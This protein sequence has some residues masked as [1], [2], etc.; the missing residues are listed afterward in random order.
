MSNVIYIDV[1][2]RTE[3]FFNPDLGGGLN[4]TTPVGFALI[5]QKW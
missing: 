3:T 5:A 4:F 2:I 1:K